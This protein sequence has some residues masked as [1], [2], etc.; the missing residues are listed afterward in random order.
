MNYCEDP[1]TL[2]CVRW[3]RD[4]GHFHL[5]RRHWAQLGA[6]PRALPVQQTQEV[7]HLERGATP[8]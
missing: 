3:G 6:S 7:P 2:Y 4:L 5:P 1:G 8:S